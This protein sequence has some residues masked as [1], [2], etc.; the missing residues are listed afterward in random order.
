M[1]CQ[2]KIHSERSIHQKDHEKARICKLLKDKSLMGI[3]TMAKS[4][5]KEIVLKFYANFKY[6]IFDIF[7]P[8]FHKVYVMSNIFYFSPML[9]NTYLN[10]LAV[11]S[12]GQKKFDVTLD[13]NKAIVELIGFSLTI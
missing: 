10:C 1:V 5:N 4:F 12:N 9:I 2:R 11:G 3:V 8:Q 13:M 7:A 6:N